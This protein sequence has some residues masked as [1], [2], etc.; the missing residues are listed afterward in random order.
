VHVCPCF[1]LYILC[2]EAEFMR[3]QFC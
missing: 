3:V 1:F 2:T